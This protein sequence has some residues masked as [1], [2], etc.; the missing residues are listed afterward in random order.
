M[1]F[2]TL[3]VK[4]LKSW[5]PDACDL[6]EIAGIELL[7]WQRDVLE[8]WLEH[9]SKGNLARTSGTLIVPRR[10]GK[11][12][13]LMARMLFG[14]YVLGENRVSYTAHDARTAA[15]TY[16]SMKDLVSRPA[17]LRHVRPSFRN[18]NGSERIEFR[19][20]GGRRARWTPSTRTGSAGRGLETDLLVIDEAMMATP[21]NMAALTPLVARSQ[22]AGR[23]QILA[24]SSAGSLESLVL[25]GLRDR[26]RELHGTTGAGVAYHEYASP[27]EAEITDEAAWKAANPSL[28]TALITTDFLKTQL[29]L[30]TAESF[31][32]EHMGAWGESALLP[33]IAPEA[34]AAA[35]S[36]ERPVLDGGPVWFAFDLDPQ[37]TSARLLLFGRTKRGI[38]VAH[39]LEAIDRPDGLSESAFAG[40][41]ERHAIEWAPEVI[42][43]DG[44]TGEYVARHLEAEG[45]KTIRL[46]LPK[47]AAACA[48][49]LTAVNEGRI[50]HDGSEILAA[51]LARAIP[52]PYNDGG[53]TFSRVKVTTGPIA[54]A[55]ALTIGHYLASHPDYGDDTIAIS[56]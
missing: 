3:R 46:P 49:L 29:A 40:L 37:R 20:P 55:I 42:G 48:M 2:G 4:R 24:A 18:A 33:A 41:V 31:R 25:L 38:V 14:L 43:Y 30:N 6:M 8:Q 44:L 1:T 39:V 16:G 15:E 28:G 11:T 17:L 7:P 5:G 34:W 27:D 21:E 36:L 32:R 23:G 26:G 9:D 51:D 53:W 12:A 47:Y 56:A 50:V 13:L 54:G 19:F 10:N 45:H 52:K 22:A 35:V